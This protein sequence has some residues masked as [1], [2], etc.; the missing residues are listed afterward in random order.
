MLFHVVCSRQALLV[1]GAV[2]VTKLVIKQRHGGW[3]LITD[4]GTHTAGVKS[5]RQAVGGLASLL[6]NPFVVVHE[7]LIW[8]GYHHVP[9]QKLGHG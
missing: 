6:N 8:T 5:V 3:G 9:S 1:Q 2:Q 7:G 4:A